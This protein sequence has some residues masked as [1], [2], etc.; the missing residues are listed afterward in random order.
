MVGIS[1]TPIAAYNVKI[2]G[3]II[4]NV[5]TKEIVNGIITEIE[6][7]EN[8]NSKYVMKSKTQISIEEVSLGRKRI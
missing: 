7:E 4:G 8:E 6:T 2:N 1:N 3:E 5:L